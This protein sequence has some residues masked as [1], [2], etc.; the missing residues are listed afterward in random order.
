MARAIRGATVVREWEGPYTNTLLYRRR[1]EACGRIPTTPPIT[2]RCLPGQTVM[3][4]CYHE[5]GFVCPFCGHRQV[6]EL[7]G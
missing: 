7:E 4:G 1:C 6:V 3:H 2:V 5:E